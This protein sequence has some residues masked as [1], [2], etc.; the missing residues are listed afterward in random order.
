MIKLNAADSPDG[1]E[2]LGVCKSFAIDF[3]NNSI[4]VNA[5][6]S[7]PCLAYKK[8]MFIALHSPLGKQFA[9]LS[10]QISR[11]SL[12]TVTSGRWGIPTSLGN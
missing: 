6:K 5:A 12:W 9:H 4:Q 10:E 8:N 1:E 2:S 3:N 7:L 11:Q